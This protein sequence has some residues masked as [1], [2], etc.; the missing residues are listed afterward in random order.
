M[1][2]N[3]KPGWFGSKLNDYG[4]ALQSGDYSAIPWIFCVFAE[5]HTA[6][7]TVAAELLCAALEKMTFDELVRIDEQMRQTTS[8]EWSIN[9]RN[10]STL[11]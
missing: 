9:W 11:W 7:K 2:W 10:Y 5:N 1:F 6:S 3:N 4:S 8:M